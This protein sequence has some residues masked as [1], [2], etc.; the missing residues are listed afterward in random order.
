MQSAA[1]NN[2][3]DHMAELE[4]SPAFITVQHYAED[5]CWGFYTLDSKANRSCLNSY[6]ANKEQLDSPL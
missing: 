2:P 1:T 3:D 5:S 4:P 6:F